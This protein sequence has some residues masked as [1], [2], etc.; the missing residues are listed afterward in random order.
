MTDD[1][2]SEEEVEVKSKP[3]K[4]PNQLG[5]ALNCKFPALVC[6]LCHDVVE[7]CI[8]GILYAKC[9]MPVQLVK[10][11]HLMSLYEVVN[12]SEHCSQ[13]LKQAIRRAV[14]QVNEHCD[15]SRY[16][17]YQIPPC[18]PASVYT[19]WQAREAIVAAGVLLKEVMKVSELQEMIG[20][21]QELPKALL[22][23]GSIS[24]EYSKSLI[25]DF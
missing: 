20:E 2:D 11:P 5:G 1:K 13:E 19:E 12:G 22:Q 6:F 16:P 10:V 21:L 14:H 23:L 18:A 4:Q 25:H 17:N 8:K 24:D 3:I 15:A 7:K 9:G